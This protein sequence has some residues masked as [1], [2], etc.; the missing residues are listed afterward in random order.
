MP[1]RLKQPLCHD[2]ASDADNTT[3]P[4]PEQPLKPEEFTPKHQLDNRQCDAS[5]RDG[6]MAYIRQPMSSAFVM[7]PAQE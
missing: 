6:I 4:A 7:P 5:Q 3:H 2:R 1:P